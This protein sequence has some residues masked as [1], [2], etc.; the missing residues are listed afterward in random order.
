MGCHW[1][2]LLQDLPPVGWEPSYQVPTLLLSCCLL[3][4]LAAFPNAEDNLF[5]PQPQFPSKPFL[6]IDLYWVK[7]EPWLS[8]CVSE[9]PAIGDIEMVFGSCSADLHCLSPCRLMGLYSLPCYCVKFLL[10]A[11]IHGD[12]ETQTPLFFFFLF[13]VARNKLPSLLTMVW[14]SECVLE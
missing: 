14:H 12:L 11:I 8:W 10:A 13:P 4:A 2:L 5:L 3:I 7:K 1:L 9:A 6:L